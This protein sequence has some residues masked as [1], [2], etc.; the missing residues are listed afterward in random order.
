VLR[1]TDDLLLIASKLDPKHLLSLTSIDQQFLRRLRP[2]SR[3][4]AIL[5]SVWE[6]L[7]DNLQRVSPFIASDASR[8]HAEV[9]T[10]PNFR[11]QRQHMHFCHIVNINRGAW[12]REV[13]FLAKHRREG[14]GVGAV[15]DVLG[16]SDELVLAD[17]EA[18]HYI[19][20]FKM[21]LF[22]LD[23]S[24]GGIEGID[25]AGGITLEWVL[26]WGMGVRD[27]IVGSEDSIT[28]FHDE[29]FPR[30]HLHQFR[31]SVALRGM[32]FGVIRHV[33]GAKTDA[34]VPKH[35]LQLRNGHERGRD[36]QKRCIRL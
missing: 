27:A 25:F 30:Y 9:L 11:V 5:D 14:D 15:E 3:Q 16:V 33:L 31:N 32:Y 8:H 26:E 19:R 23:E 18:G 24:V 21:R 7:F 1:N 29:L 28:L 2:V 10:A 35:V 13:G 6:P 4:F 20:D 34:L 36:K 12:V 17:E 22:G